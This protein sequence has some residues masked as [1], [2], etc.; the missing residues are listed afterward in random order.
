MC[1]R[2]HAAFVPA[3]GSSNSESASVPTDTDYEHS[4][5]KLILGS[6]VPLHSGLKCLQF[7]KQ[8]HPV[9]LS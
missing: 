8:D 9:Q 5:L 1:G 3:A 4:I 7:L 6:P 2:V